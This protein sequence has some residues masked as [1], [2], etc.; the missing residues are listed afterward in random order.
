MGYK[1]LHLALPNNFFILLPDVRQRK[2]L[3]KYCLVI[4]KDKEK[5]EEALSLLCACYHPSGDR[6]VAGYSNGTSFIT[7]THDCHF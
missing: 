2:V 1:I 5:E 3:R 4:E 7:V 6:F